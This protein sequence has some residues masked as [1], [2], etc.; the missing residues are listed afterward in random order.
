M[1]SA[2]DILELACRRIADL[3]TPA[4]VKNS[5]L[6]YVAVNE[7]YADFL[8]REIS[9]FI[10]RRSRELFDRPEEE[11]REDKERRAL[12]FG[13]EE[14]AICFD[15]ANL[16]HERIQIESFSPSPERI[17]VLGI[18]EARE[19]R[20][21]G[22]RE[23][24]GS[25]QTVNDF[26][27]AADLAWVREALEKLDHPIGIFAADGRP[28]VVNAAH[29][30]GGHPSP[31]GD[32]AW[33]DSVNELDAL[34]TVLEDLPVA[35]F[36]RDDQHRL[37]YANKY[38]ETFSGRARSEYLGMTEHEMFGPEGAEPIYQE[39]LL[40]LR[41]GISVE[42]ES[43][44]PSTGDHVYPVISRVNRVIT[45]DGRTYVVGSF[46]DISPLKEREKA[47]IEAK[48]QEEVLHRDIESIL[49]LL[50]IGV[51]I[52]DNDH[53]ILSVNDEFYSIWELPLDDRFDGR[54][55]IDVIRRNEELGRYDGT[56]TPEE[57]YAF[58][59]HLFETD[60]PEPIELGW[61][62]GKSVIFDSRRISNDRILLTY[63]DISAVREREKEIHETRAALERVG[64]M[65]RDATHAMSQG[66]AIVQDGIIK[67]SNEA[68]ADILQIPASY[69]AAGQGWL[70]MFEF[71]AARGDFHDA[72]DEILQEWRANIAARQ[73]ISTVFHVGGER[74]VNMD[75]TVSEGQHWVALFTDVTDLKSR[76]EELRQ[77]LSRAEAADRA[78]SEFLANMSHEIRTPMNG[79]L[80]MA[81]L[82][83]KSNLDT[84][85]KTFVDIIVKS[86]NALLTIINDILDFSKIDA[87]QMKLRRAAFD[88]TEAVED[89][90]TLLSSHAAEKNIELLVRAAPDLPAAVIGDA[91]RFRQIVTN[92]VGNAVKFTERGHVFVDVGFQAAGGGE[93][94]ASI[95]IEDTGIGIPA[96]KLESVFDK[97]SQ[98]DASSTRRH[99][100]TGLGLAITA[101]LVDLFGGYLNVESE[102][103]KGSVFTVNLPFAVAAARLEPK[104]LPINVQGARILVVDDND[105]NRRILTEQLS[106]WGFDGVAA[107]GGG[108]GLAILEA[109]AELGV[110]V[111]AVVLDYHM[112]DM[113]GAD[114]ARR[115]RADRRFADLPIIFL[116]S[117]D[118]SGTEKEFAALNGHAHLM[119][120]ARAN[121]LR[122]TVVEVVRAS[123]V[124]QASE[125][126]IARLQ[127]EAAAPV[128]AP[129]PVPPQRAAEFVD[130]LVAEDN[131]VNQIVFTQ[132]LQGTGLSFLVVENGEEAVAAWERHTPRIIMMD[133]S[134]PVMNG[135]QA[136]QTIREREKGQGHRVPIIGVTAHALESDR[137]LCLDAGMDDYM[138][139]PISPELLEEKI[140][141]WLGKDEQ[142]PGRSSY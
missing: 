14:N 19:R 106:L 75:A 140:R 84:R 102:W 131:E 94:M 73:P 124:K 52:L 88:I 42:L 8:G 69:I 71:C 136:T 55:F 79:V 3:D 5:E 32:S 35:V 76:E 78:K 119:K 51:L 90:A 21:V 9:D 43:E 80:G 18:F 39:N 138:S 49:R 65:M 117:M 128:P 64:E 63:A 34:R 33:G 26:G 139:K 141:Q 2:G 77:L 101:G 95:R 47:L 114:V 36:V 54:P 123:R 28:L 27:P 93:I 12:V 50:P 44:M 41:D 91:G 92:L 30:K 37:I 67:M 115:L 45:A 130:V 133:V 60:E 118:I 122:N 112:P 17:Y 105:V 134:M 1:K 7:A 142:Q 53:R 38:Y 66:L 16:Q 87:G 10:G 59:K 4:Y 108:T 89:V 25:S 56:Q 11:D 113:N 31:A 13:S 99:E 126:E 96:E 100:G 40:A 72:A 48:K 81:E 127:A 85:Q 23:I 20:A 74:W 6:R 46:S 83:A 103:G 125:A 86:G 110:T 15:A 135:H 137:E 109:A 62:G 29:R 68:M 57:I 82:L 22:K 129:A 107:E 97:F 61:A 121:V 70:G 111:D 116:T 132:I 24:G 120:P 98:V 58:R 104:P